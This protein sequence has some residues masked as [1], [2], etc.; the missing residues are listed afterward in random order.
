MNWEVDSGKW[1]VGGVGIMNWEVDSGKW[2][3]G[4]QS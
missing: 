1:E 4:G 3:V 2:E